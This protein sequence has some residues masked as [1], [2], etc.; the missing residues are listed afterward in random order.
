MSAA[1]FHCS[2]FKRK[3][4]FRVIYLL[5][6]IDINTFV[7]YSLVDKWR[8]LVYIQGNKAALYRLGTVPHC[9]NWVQIGFVWSHC[10]VL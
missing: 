9:T 5:L 10:L 6:L 8:H 1:C 4:S 3:S 2:T 7:N